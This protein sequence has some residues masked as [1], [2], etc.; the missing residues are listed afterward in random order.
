MKLQANELRL[1]NWVT[2][3]NPEYRPKE[4]GIP[5]QVTEVGRSSKGT[6]IGVEV[7]NE[8][9]GQFI[10]FIEPIPLTEDWLLKFG[11]IEN[12]TSFSTWDVPTGVKELRLKKQAG[13]LFYNGLIIEH[14]HQ[15]QNLY[16]ALTSQELTIKK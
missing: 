6:V 7:N 10:R 8:D 11:I 12:S 13:Y 15:L 16:F 5:T 1:G 9:F 2:V 4:T 14:V 3:N